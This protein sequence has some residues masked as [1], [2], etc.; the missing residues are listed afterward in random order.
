[1]FGKTW[2]C[3]PTFSM[4]NFMKSKCQ[5]SISNENLMTKLGCIANVKS[6]S[7]FSDCMWKKG[8]IFQWIFILITC[9]NDNFLLSWVKY[10][11]KIY[12]DHFLYLFIHSLIHLFILRNPYAQVDLELMIPRSSPMLHWL[13]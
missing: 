5:L 12:F 4:A 9:W 10:I 13:S 6:I 8:K 11:I 3:W 1:M 2:V 7:D